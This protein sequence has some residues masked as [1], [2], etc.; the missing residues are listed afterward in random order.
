MIG[1]RLALGAGVVDGDVEPAEAGDGGI[2]QALYVVLVTH[3]GGDEFRLGAERAKL[4]G[5]RLA[6]LFV[7]A[8]DD[9]T[10]TLLGESERGGAADAGQGAGDRGR[11][12][13]SCSF[14]FAE[15]L[16]A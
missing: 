11:R 8:G 9:D 2:N 16:A 3:V 4:L 10:R 14:S 13:Y 15:S 7:A 5:Q 12:D 6:G 1:P